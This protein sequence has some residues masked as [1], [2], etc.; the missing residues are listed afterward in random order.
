VGG[1]KY[2]RGGNRK[3]T[4]SAR[5]SAAAYAVGEFLSCA[6][7]HTWATTVVGSGLTRPGGVSTLLHARYRDVRRIS[8]SPCRFSRGSGAPNR[9]YAWSTAGTASSTV[10]ARTGWRL[11]ALD[12]ARQCCANN[13]SNG[14]GSRS[15]RWRGSNC[16]LVQKVSQRR[17]L[18]SAEAVRWRETQRVVA[19]KRTTQGGVGG[20]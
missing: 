4:P 14:M 16:K 18:E 17:Q 19:S 15:P 13:W 12:P 2:S 10:R 20:G 11:G 3:Y 8:S 5:I 7:D 6:R 1:H 9:A